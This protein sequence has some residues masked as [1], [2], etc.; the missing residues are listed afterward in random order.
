MKTAFRCRRKMWWFRSTATAFSSKTFP[1]TWLKRK[2]A[3]CSCRDGHHDSSP[4]GSVKSRKCEFRCGT[5]QGVRRACATW[6]IWRTKASNWRSRRAALWKWRAESCWLTW[7]REVP[8]TRSECRTALCGRISTRRSEESEWIRK[9][10]VL[11]RSGQKLNEV[12]I[13]YSICI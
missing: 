8:R 9:E 4:G 7:S 1:M 13:E 6:T 11:P 5:T 2:S 10:R 3:P 12:F